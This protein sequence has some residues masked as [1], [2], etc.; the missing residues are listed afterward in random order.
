MLILFDVDMA[1]DML[2]NHKIN[3]VVTEL[4]IRSIKLNISPVFEYAMLLYQNNNSLN[5]K[6]YFIMKF[7]N[8]RELQ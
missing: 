6:H 4:F 1:A 7:L 3:P 8:K 2:R 5:S